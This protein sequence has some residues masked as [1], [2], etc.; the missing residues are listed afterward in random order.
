MNN[1]E[2][3][4]KRAY[5]EDLP[6][7]IEIYDSNIQ[8]VHGIKRDLHTWKTLFNNPNSE[9]YIAYS[10][11]YLGWFRIDYE[12]DFEL[13]MIQVAPLHQRSGVGKFIIKTV[14]EIAKA[15]GYKTIIIH[16]TK[17]N[18]TAQKLYKTCEYS[19]TEEGLCHTAD[20]VERDGLTFKKDL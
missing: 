15:K 20:G 17:D 19:L 16:T 14:E 4:Y 8:A 3:K 18:N 10:D 1:M 7:I 13:G 5:L 12:D 2:L 6:F 9:Y 11:I